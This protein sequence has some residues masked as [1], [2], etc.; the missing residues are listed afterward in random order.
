VEKIKID[1]DRIKVYRGKMK[2]LYFLFLILVAGNLYCLNLK[3]V[4]KEKK[5][6]TYIIKDQSY[7]SLKSF[8]EAVNP[9]SW[10]KIEDRVFLIYNGT[11]IKFRI[12][13]D[14]VKVKDKTINLNYPPK[15]IEGEILI[16]LDD[17]SSIISMISK[18]KNLEERKQ[19]E[20]KQRVGE[21]KPYIILI[22]PGHGGKDAGA[23]GNFGL[24]EK[25]VN[26]DVSLRLVNYLHRQM[27]K[28]SYIKIF[29]TRN[30]DIFLTLEKRVQMAKDINANMFFCVH[31]NSSRY[32]R[33]RASGFETYYP[34]SKEEVENLPE[35]TNNEGV[36]QD[37]EIKDI[38]LARILQDLNTTNVVEESRILA[39]FVQEKLAERLLT[40]D[41]G[42]RQ[43]NFYVLK[44][45]P[46][47]SI[48]VEIGFICNPNI[49]LN[50]RD[51]EVR[52]AIAESL[53]NAII[54]YLKSRKIIEE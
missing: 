10:G 7:I 50:L 21:K 45:T 6:P 46:M 3:E 44:Y 32:N 47:V 14:I 35:V 48:L 31:T 13:E 15:E 4:I 16:P 23:V 28:Y 37:E 25:D 26:L 52:Q 19:K 51:A 36:L 39:E 40:P 18:N 49:E 41:R 24:K 8:I 29:L 9:E 20:I 34:K 30:R 53:G 1:R 11:E 17:F 54:E 12:N 38:A 43:G 27:E 2:K 33:Y 5:F 42:A 22:D